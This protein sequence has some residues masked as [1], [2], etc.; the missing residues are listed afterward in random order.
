[1]VYRYRSV[2][3]D[4]NDILRLMTEKGFQDTNIQVALLGHNNN[5][6][7]PQVFQSRFLKNVMP[8]LLFIYIQAK[9][10]NIVNF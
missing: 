5:A 8:N 7:I 4:L 6:S 10:Q 1:M 9:K 2:F 3:L